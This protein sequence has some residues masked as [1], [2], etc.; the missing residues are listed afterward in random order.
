MTYYDQ[1][2]LM[3]LKLQRW[4]PSEPHKAD[5]AEARARTADLVDHRQRN[6]P[7]A[8]KRRPGQRIGRFSIFRALI[9]DK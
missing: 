3:M 7:P 2:T 8:T 6:A 9:F 5:T 4:A 1:A